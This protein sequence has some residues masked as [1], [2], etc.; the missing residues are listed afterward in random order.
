MGRKLALP[1]LILTLLVSC[2]NFVGF[3]KSSGPDTGDLKSFRIYLTQENY[4]T[5]RNSVL[6][7]R[8]APLKFEDNRANPFDEDRGMI[9]IR[10]NSSRYR[11]KKSYTIEL[12]EGDDAVRYALDAGADVWF[13]YGLAMAAYNFAGIHCP[14]FDPVALYINDDYWGYY[15]VVQLYNTDL[16]DAYGDSKGQLFKAD[17]E[18]P[19]ENGDINSESEKK[20]PDDSDFSLFNRLFVNANNMTTE[21]WVAWIET[22][23]VADFEGMADYMVVRDF[24]GIRDVD[25]G[26]YYIYFYDEGFTILPW[27]SDAGYRYSEIG[28]NNLITKRMLESSVFKDLYTAKMKAYFTDSMPGSYTDMLDFA[29]DYVVDLYGVLEKAAEVEPYGDYSDFISEFNYLLDFFDDRP[30]DVIDSNPD[31]DFS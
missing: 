26:N 6:T 20:F 5:L 13:Q 16:N 23:G 29:Y 18:Y 22:P 1:L 4:T 17:F 31:W 8:W 19:A 9:R 2:G 21:E 14:T 27:D 3:S 11:P 24:F 15:N 28:G 25:R 12:G 30:A 10:G 7:G